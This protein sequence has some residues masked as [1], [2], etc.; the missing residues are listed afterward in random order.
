M[1]LFFLTTR[2]VLVGRPGGDSLYSFQST[3]GR[4]LYTGL[5][6]GVQ[7]PGVYYGPTELKLNSYGPQ[8]GEMCL[9]P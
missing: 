3:K 7:L 4:R 1:S 9:S 8:L 5:S 6:I 2:N